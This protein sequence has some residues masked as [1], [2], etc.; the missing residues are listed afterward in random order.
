MLEKWFLSDWSTLG[1]VIGSTLLMYLL[2]IVYTRLAGLRS[3]AKLSGFEFASTLATGS[4]LAS[5]AVSKSVTLPMGAAAIGV[6]YLSDLAIGNLRRR[7]G[8][9][10]FDNEPLLLVFDKTI[11]GPAMARANMTEDD[12]RAKLREANVLDPSS[13]RAVIMET[14][15]DVSVLHGNGEVHDDMLRDVVD[16]RSETS[17]TV[18]TT[19]VAMRK[20][21]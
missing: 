6:L 1:A 8:F 7:F 10:A 17:G 13:V 4:I 20:L 19:Y 21:D 9:G 11:I 5:T 3:F 14:T 2:V 18:E 15:G 16:L 12:L